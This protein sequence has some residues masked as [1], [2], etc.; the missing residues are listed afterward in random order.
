MTDSNHE[1]QRLQLKDVQ[2]NFEQ[3]FKVPAERVHVDGSA[4]REARCAA[5]HV[6]DE[7]RALLR[8][9]K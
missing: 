5:E 9:L 6:M 1:M 2:D 7:I 3:I 4:L 8:K